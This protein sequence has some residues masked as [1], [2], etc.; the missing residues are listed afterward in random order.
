[1]MTN[2]A[3]IV[4]GSE[5]AIMILLFIIFFLEYLFDSL[6]IILCLG[7]RKHNSN[8][9]GIVESSLFGKRDIFCPKCKS[10]DCTYVYLFNNEQVDPFD[11][12]LK[13]TKSNIMKIVRAGIIELSAVEKYKCKECGYI[14][15]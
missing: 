11:Y 3:L 14:F 5:I 6:D 2:V 10:I 9:S 15:K 12:K 7:S 1:M 8:Y 13:N 4:L